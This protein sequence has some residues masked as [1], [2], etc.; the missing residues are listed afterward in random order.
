MREVWDFSVLRGRVN[1]S[2]GSREET[3]LREPED[4]FCVLV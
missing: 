1:T 4:T 2:E 3:K